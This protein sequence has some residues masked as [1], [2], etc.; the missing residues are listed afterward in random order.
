MY[1]NH[2][3]DGENLSEVEVIVIDLSDKDG[4]QGF[5]ESCTVHVYGGADW[6]HE[7]GHTLVYI[8]VFLKAF[9]CDG[10]CCRTERG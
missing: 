7:T 2:L 10:Q 1:L 5:I 4:C 6:E 3:P 8:V 9:K